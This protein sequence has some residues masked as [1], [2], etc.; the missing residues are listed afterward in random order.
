MSFDH[1]TVTGF[2]R[3]PIVAMTSTQHP[4]ATGDDSGARLDSQ[5]DL[6]PLAQLPPRPASH[7]PL[8][9][10]V[11]STAAPSPLNRASRNHPLRWPTTDGALVEVAGEI[12][13]C[14][15]G[16]MRPC[17][18]LNMP[19]HLAHS[20]AHV[21]ADWST[22]G[23]LMGSGRGADETELAALLHH[24]ADQTGDDEARRCH[25]PVVHSAG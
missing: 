13:D 5:M 17:V 14:D 7:V 24:A 20:L 18:S 16:A 3:A 12:Q 4:I 9:E 2:R 25:Q 19:G 15:A 22:I 11:R 21:L 1:S 6:V 10:L 8:F 23:D